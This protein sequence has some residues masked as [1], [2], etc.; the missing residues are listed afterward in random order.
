MFFNSILILY[1]QKIFTCIVSMYTCACSGWI[2]FET[3][4]LYTHTSKQQ[5]EG[6]CDYTCTCKHCYVV[7]ALFVTVGF[8]LYLLLLL[9]LSPSIVWETKVTVILFV[10]KW[11][12][13]IDEQS[14]YWLLLLITLQA[15]HSYHFLRLH[16]RY[17][18]VH[19]NDV[20]H[21]QYRYF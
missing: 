2:S 5:W 4:I 16:C 15:S 3:C 13:L 12:L 17:S 6:L 20:W 1:W 7:L 21:S 19:T 10:L 18:T 9:L 8:L 11:I 14:C